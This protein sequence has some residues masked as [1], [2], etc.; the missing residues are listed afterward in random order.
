MFNH[1]YNSY[2]KYAYPYDELRPLTCEGFD[3]WGRYVLRRQLA[4]FRS[5]KF[6][7]Y[8]CKRVLCSFALTLIDSLD[9]LVVFGNYSEFRRVV[10]LLE[11]IDFDQ[12]I[13]VSVFETNIRGQ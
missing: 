8:S 6:V 11:S 13:N 2:M 7:I 12:E 3:T 4:K 1:A 10:K 9:A 5:L